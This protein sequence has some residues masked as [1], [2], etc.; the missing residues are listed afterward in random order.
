MKNPAVEAP[1]VLHARL[2]A[3]E[4]VPTSALAR[5]LCTSCVFIRSEASSAGRLG[6]RVKKEKV[7]DL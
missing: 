3:T 4:K 2:V 7:V 5:P 6:V 1:F